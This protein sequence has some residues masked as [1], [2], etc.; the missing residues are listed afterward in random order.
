MA[1]YYSLDVIGQRMGV[2]SGTV[3][4]WWRTR[5]FLMY[6]RR[7]LGRTIWY[8]N[9]DL[10]KTWEITQCAKDFSAGPGDGHGPGKRKREKKGDVDKPLGAST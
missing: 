8:T 5:R 4:R 3:W 6:R 7:R 1:E 2:H 9:D 10:I